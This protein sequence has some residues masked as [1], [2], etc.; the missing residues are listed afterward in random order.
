MYALD[1]HRVLRRYRRRDVP[2]Q[3]VAVMRHARA[4]GY[5]APDI[6]SVA[7]PD[8]VLERIDGPTMREDIERD[9]SVVERHARLL[10]ALHERLA[11]IEA[12][13]WTRAVGPGTSLVHLDLHPENV[14]IARDGP[15]V[16]D[17]ANAA[18]GHWADDVAQT[19][20]ILRGAL[21]DERLAGLIDHFVEVFL[22]AFDRQAVRAHLDAAIARRVADPNLSD[23]ERRAAERVRA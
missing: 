4:R 17:W 22:A 20:V 6:Y 11:A 5:P 16:I 9:L 10:A 14:L 19:V 23:E 21:V 15:R 13:A 3:E 7:G 8:L 2:E 18:R 1:E 12:P